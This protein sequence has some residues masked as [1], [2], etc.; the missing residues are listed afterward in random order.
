MG[1]MNRARILC[2]QEL[3]L[4]LTKKIVKLMTGA[5]VRDESLESAV[6]GAFIRHNGV[7]AI[8]DQPLGEQGCSQK[9]A[10]SKR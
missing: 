10:C 4:L 2:R 5:S 7:Q 3:I 6:V 8:S 9:T 1:A